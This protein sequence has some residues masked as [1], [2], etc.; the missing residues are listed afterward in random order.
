M[1]I[2]T[3]QISECMT[4]YEQRINK[5]TGNC[6]TPIRH[7]EPETHQ[8]RAEHLLYMCQQVREWCG[9]LPDTLEWTVEVYKDRE[10]QLLPYLSLREKIMRWLSWIQAKLH[11]EGLLTMEQCKRDLMPP[12][13]TFRADGGVETREGK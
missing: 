9:D 3:K 4:R 6:A 2:A 5:W 11:S 7:E 12:D 1:A 13:A 10:K 8:A